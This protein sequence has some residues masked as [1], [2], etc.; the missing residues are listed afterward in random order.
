MSTIPQ[1]LPNPLSSPNLKP[2]SEHNPLAPNNQP[3]P[4]TTTPPRTPTDSAAASTPEVLAYETQQRKNAADRIGRGKHSSGHHEDPNRGDSFHKPHPKKHPGNGQPLNRRLDHDCGLEDTRRALAES[5][6]NR[7][8]DLTEILRAIHAHPE[9]AYR[10]HFA[11]SMLV[12]AVRTAYPNL[13]VTYPAFGID[14]A[15]AVEANQRRL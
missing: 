4:C 11:S 3:P 15:F 14:T 6:T 1:T 8:S 10:E 12:E 2:R 7:A 13:I 9:T 5:I